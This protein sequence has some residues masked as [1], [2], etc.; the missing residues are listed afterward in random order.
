MTRKVETEFAFDIGDTLR[1]K[2]WAFTTDSRRYDKHSFRPD[3]PSCVFRVMGLVAQLSEGEV[4]ERSYVVRS[5]MDAGGI[6]D[7]YHT[8]K[9]SEVELADP[10]PVEPAHKED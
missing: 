6:S 10:L 2:G 8:L 5:V 1:H 7:R 4:I 3:N 9:E